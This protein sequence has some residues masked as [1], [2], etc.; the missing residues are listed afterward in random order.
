[1]SWPTMKNICCPLSNFDV[2]C[3]LIKPNRK[4][5]FFLFSCNQSLLSPKHNLNLFLR[6]LLFI[7]KLNS[8]AKA[9]VGCLVRKGNATKGKPS[10]LWRL[11][12]SEM[13][14]E[15][16]NSGIPRLS[17]TIQG[18]HLDNP[19]N[20]TTSKRLPQGISSH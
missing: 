3:K 9:W 1:M 8:V 10:G 20:S 17:R 5:F 11:R 6:T 7:L 12:Q 14:T 19:G 13:G 15:R 16:I 18:Q 4:N 2:K